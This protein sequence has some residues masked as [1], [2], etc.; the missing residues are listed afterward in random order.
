MSAKDDLRQTY[1]VFS[2]GSP[3]IVLGLYEDPS[4]QVEFPP[5]SVN[6]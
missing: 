4:L 3:F 2:S 1:K 5:G 6:H